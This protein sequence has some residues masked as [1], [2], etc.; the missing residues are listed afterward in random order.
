MNHSSTLSQALTDRLS[1][2]AQARE[3]RYFRLQETARLHREQAQHVLCTRAFALCPK[4][5]RL[6]AQGVCTQAAMTVSGAGES[7]TVIARVDECGDTNWLLTDMSRL[8][9]P[10]PVYIAAVQARIEANRIGT[11]GGAN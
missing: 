7:V 3:G 9:Y 2:Q 11:S 10:A 1:D 6:T 5:C 8:T 4:L